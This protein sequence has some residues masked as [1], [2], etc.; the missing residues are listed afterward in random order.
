MVLFTDEPSK[1]SNL[2]LIMWCSGDM[3]GW[4]KKKKKKHEGEKGELTRAAV[5]GM[6]NRK[7]VMTDKSM[8]EEHDIDTRKNEK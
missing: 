1:E 5:D 6:K 4:E 2:F 3:E 7:Q 8:K